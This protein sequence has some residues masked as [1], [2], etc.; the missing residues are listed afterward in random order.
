MKKK[1]SNTCNNGKNSLWHTWRLKFSTTRKT[2]FHTLSQTWRLKFSTTRRILFHTLSQ[3]WRLKFSTTRRI[4]FHTLSQSWRLKFS[5][6][7]RTLFHKLSQTWRL[8]FSIT[9]R[10]LFQ[11]KTLKLDNF[12]KL[13]EQIFPHLKKLTTLWR[14]FFHTSHSL[15]KFY[16]LLV[17]TTTFFATLQTQSLSSKGFSLSMLYK[18][19][20]W[21][22][23]VLIQCPFSCLVWAHNLLERTW[24]QAR[25]KTLMVHEMKQLY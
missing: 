2:L 4:L 19:N 14:N 20:P 10:I 12:K 22:L 18:L 8:K 5:I 15:E 1:T 3:S 25:N 16:N 21:L 6:T 13:G 24:K 11:T 17:W 9:Q 7:R 23:L